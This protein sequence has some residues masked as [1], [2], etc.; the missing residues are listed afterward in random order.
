M[1]DS[2]LETAMTLGPRVLF[3][4]RASSDLGRFGM[5]LKTAS[6][7]QCRCLTVASRRERAQFPACAASDAAAASP[8]DGWRM[9]G[10]ADSWL[11]SFR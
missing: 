5:G 6:F 10:G 4:E 2:E 8:D 11:R 7:S 3:D 9:F 1:D